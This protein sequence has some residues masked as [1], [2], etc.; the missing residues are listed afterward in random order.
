[1]LFSTN[2]TPAE[3]DKRRERFDKLRT[4]MK[5]KIKIIHFISKTNQ[6]D[7]IVKNT[8]DNKKVIKDFE[9]VIVNIAKGPARN[10][11]LKELPTIELDTSVGKVPITSIAKSLHFGGEPTGGGM[12]GATAKG[13][14]LQCVMLDALL[15]H[16]TDN[17][18]IA[19]DI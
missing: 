1:M 5:D 14:S 3:W 12:S 17:N 18:G 7:M 8:A 4:A 10:K 6:E 13:E 11:A 16:G 9:N 19:Q 2:L 15:T